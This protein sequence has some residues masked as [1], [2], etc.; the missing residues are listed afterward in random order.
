MPLI[1]VLQQHVKCPHLD[2]FET[3]TASSVLISPSSP[4]RL[5]TIYLGLWISAIVA[6][7]K[8]QESE[9]DGEAVALCIW[10]RCP[11]SMSFVIGSILVKLLVWTRVPP[12]LIPSLRARASVSTC[13]HVRASSPLFRVQRALMSCEKLPMWLIL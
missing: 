12:G 10:L 9:L 1:D 8:L 13:S 7:P 2:F 11:C 3:R 6:F 5:G 4:D